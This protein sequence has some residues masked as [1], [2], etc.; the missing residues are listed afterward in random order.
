MLIFFDTEFTDLHQDAQLISIGL[1]SED[2]K[3]TFY[4]EL[5]DTYQVKDCS[6]FV[7]QCVLPILE[8]GDAAMT[9]AEMAERLLLWLSNFNG[10]VRLVTDSMAW[11][12]RWIQGVF[13]KASAWPENVDRKPAIIGQDAEMQLAIEHAFGYGLRPHHALDDAKA[14]R[15]GWLNGCQPT[16]GE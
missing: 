1:V 8:G 2:G 5:T 16:F 4:A 9:M 13:Q 3:Q 14:N 7:K 10:P 12:W 6:D 11:D 15:Q